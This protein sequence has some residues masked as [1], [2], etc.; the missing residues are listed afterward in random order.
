MVEFTQEKV[1]VQDLVTG[2]F[3]A[4]LDR[5]WVGTPFPI[6]GFHIR[7]YD[8]I[9]LL[10]AL[11]RYV[12]IDVVK[13]K[14]SLRDIRNRSAKAGRNR[15]QKLSRIRAS[16]ASYKTTRTLKQEIPTASSLHDDVAYAIDQVMTNL[17]SGKPVQLASMRKLAKN[18]VDSI[19]RNPDAAMW[20]ARIRNQD[21]YLYGH[22]VRAAIWAITFGRHLE[23]NRER[24]EHLA[25]G[26]LLSEVGYT[27][28]PRELSSK[29]CGLTPA[30]RE[31]VRQHVTHGVDILK[32][33]KGI[34]D[35]IV[36]VVQTHH[37]RFNGSGYPKGLRG[38]QIPLLGQIAGIV[39]D[40]DTLTI[41]RDVR[42]ALSPT[43]AMAKL[44]GMIDEEFQKE[45]I[46]EFIRAIGI[47]PTGTLVELSTG[48]IGIITEQNTERRLR[49]RILL[50][51]DAMH[52]ALKT[53]REIDLIS[54]TRD[55]DGNP[56]DILKSLPQG[57]HGIDLTQHRKG[58]FAR[59][60]RIG[61]ELL[62]Y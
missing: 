38:S 15:P 50:L 60:L 61:N 25:T 40:Y 28:L 56:V 43:V 42:D 30:E 7:N 41:P 2:M 37:E 11:C 62:R 34:D 24:L 16:E 1:D 13:S 36:S 6:Q 48:E 5:P 53:P 57:A 32:E 23:L 51:L 45:L 47:Y 27:R 8:E 55:R 54:L 10:G 29:T 4:R 44:H 39:D 22:S 49:P 17:A 21:A 20:I 18:L 12:Y 52:L 58:S 31:L 19:I 33:L 14:V 59:L 3:V 46:E 9:R 26:V 35:E